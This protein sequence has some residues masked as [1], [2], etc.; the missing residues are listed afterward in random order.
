MERKTG[1]VST[2]GPV[3][4]VD[5]GIERAIAA[6]VDV[7]RFNFSHAEQ[8]GL[9]KIAEYFQRV[10]DAREKAGRDVKIMQDLQGPKIRLGCLLNNMLVVKAGD[11]ITLDYQMFDKCMTSDGGL[12]LPVQYNLAEKVKVGENIF[13]Y[14]GKV[15]AVVTEIAS[16]TSIK[17]EA[18]ND[19]ILM[20][21]K[22]INLPDTDFGN[23]VFPEK[24][25]KDL[26]WGATQPIDWVAVSFIH[27][28]ENLRDIRKRM[29]DLGIGDRKIVA[30]IETR[31]ATHDNAVMEE[32]VKEADIIMV[33]RG[34]MAYEVGFEKVP[35]V[36]RK[37]VGLCRKHGK[38]CIVA[39]Q[40]MMS[41]METPEPSRAET[42]DV[43]N[44]Y[45]TGATHVMTSDET[46]N[47]KYPIETIDAMDKVLRYTEANV[48]Q[49][50]VEDILSSVGLA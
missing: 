22:G 13:L 1:I 17:I 28:A 18:K 32:I 19:G 34:D 36:Q 14:D 31:Q 37:L 44:A 24:D 10:I 39:T 35:T 25:V 47:G 23:D 21:R 30:K 7:A 6:G 40:T 42:S 48:K 43:A 20:S 8:E 2:I 16:D 4:F 33:A 12:K 38:P 15:Q 49:T 11:I 41:M 45:I 46:T 26:T 5:E 50:P 29:V 3:L 9:E 27:N